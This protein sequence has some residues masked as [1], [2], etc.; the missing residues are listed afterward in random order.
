MR[1]SIITLARLIRE[2][3]KFADMV[4]VPWRSLIVEFKEGTNRKAVVSPED[5]R[6]GDPYATVD[7]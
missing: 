6:E 3:K 2:A 4:E 5:W 1:V 7:Y